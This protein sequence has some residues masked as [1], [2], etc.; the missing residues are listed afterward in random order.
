MT[1]QEK[2]AELE[3]R[4]RNTIHAA[5]KARIDL[6]YAIDMLADIERHCVKE[7]DTGYAYTT[8]CHALNVLGITRK[9]VQQMIEQAQPDAQ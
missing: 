6:H 2:I 8:A 5:N 9:D 3:T 1:E 4:L 7:N